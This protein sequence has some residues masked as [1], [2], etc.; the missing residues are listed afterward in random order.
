[1]K[2]WASTLWLLSALVLVCGCGGGG[3]ISGPT[4]VPPSGPPSGPPPQ[5]PSIAG[6]WQFGTASTAQG[7]PLG[8]AGS[9]NQSGSVVSGAVHVDSFYENCFDRLTTVGLTR[10][11]Q[12]AVKRRWSTA[13]ES[14]ARELVR[15]AR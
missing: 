10:I 12:C 5:L 3:G 11:I 2:R 8:I 7:E 14:P 9:I 4:S 6:N 15:S 13:G 1:M